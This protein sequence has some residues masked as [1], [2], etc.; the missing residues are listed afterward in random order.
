MAHIMHSGES[1]HLKKWGKCSNCRS[2]SFR[3]LLPQG[4][5][6]LLGAASLTLST[7][8]PLKMKLAAERKGRICFLK[9][10]KAEA[11]KEL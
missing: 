7:S 8:M 9:L 2:V 6:S 5:A 10:Q 1:L 3:T 11:L 4:G